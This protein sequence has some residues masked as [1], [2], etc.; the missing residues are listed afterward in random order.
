MVKETK[1]RD[2]LST[3][4]GLTRPVS[5]RRIFCTI[6]IA[7]VFDN[8]LPVSIIRMQRGMISVDSKKV[9]TSGLSF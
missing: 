2:I 5:S 6:K 3:R 9:I 1:V 7:T 4:E 8:S